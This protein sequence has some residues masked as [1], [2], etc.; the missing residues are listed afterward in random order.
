MNVVG[1]IKQ[2]KKLA[3]DHGMF[4]VERPAVG[5]DATDF[6]LYR[7]TP[8]RAQRLGRRRDIKQFRRFV[9]RA[10]ALK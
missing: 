1:E 8:G 4:V 5:C 7:K 2:V 10:A 6:I 9:E 3:A